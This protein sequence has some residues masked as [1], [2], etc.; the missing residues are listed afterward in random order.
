MTHW[1][2]FSAPFTHAQPMNNIFP[3]PTTLNREESFSCPLICAVFL[4]LQF[5]CLPPFPPLLSCSP[6][7]HYRTGLLHPP[8]TKEPERPSSERTSE[9]EESQNSRKG[10][11]KNKNNF[12]I[13]F[14]GSTEINEKQDEN[15]F[16]DFWHQLQIYKHEV[17][18]Q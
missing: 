5:P 14:A 10:T 18:R 3:V 13:F 1:S 11:C 17:S 8:P 2:S 15:S 7:S 6:C 16:K 12:I 9:K 4:S